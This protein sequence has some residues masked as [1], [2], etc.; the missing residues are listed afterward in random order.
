MST[1]INPSEIRSKWNT[2]AKE[3]TTK[4]DKKSWAGDIEQHMRMER[5]KNP[6]NKCSAGGCGEKCNRTKCACMT[7]LTTACDCATAA[8]TAAAA[9]VFETEDQ[10]NPN[11]QTL[12][13]EEEENRKK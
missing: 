8:V 6:I 9:D 2:N 13:T 4:T 11:R 12:T 5:K 1:A 10:T 7:N 3:N